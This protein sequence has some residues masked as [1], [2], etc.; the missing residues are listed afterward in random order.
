MTAR[1]IDIDFGYA[2]RDVDD[3][4]VSL[5]RALTVYGVIFDSVGTVDTD[6]TAAYRLR[7]RGN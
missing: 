5:A 6:A 1:A 7:R 3:G 2:Q 4:R